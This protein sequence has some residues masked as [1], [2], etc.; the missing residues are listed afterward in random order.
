MKK[1]DPKVF[2][3]GYVALATADIERTREHYLESIGMTQTAKG[4]DG[5]VL[6]SLGYDHHNI[7]LSPADKKALLH[8]G[9]QQVLVLPL[10]SLQRMR[11]NLVL[12]RK[13]RRTLSPELQSLSRSRA[14]AK[15]S[16][17]SIAQWKRR[18]RGSG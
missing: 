16:S 9:F 18:R 12:P 14:L 15:T 3:L 7:V 4:D 10:Q 6:L 11:E 13:S 1:F 8:V 5:S 2:R 17:S